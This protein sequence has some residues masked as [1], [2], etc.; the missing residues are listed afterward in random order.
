MATVRQYSSAALQ[1]SHQAILQARSS[2]EAERALLEAF[3]DRGVAGTCAFRYPFELISAKDLDILWGEDLSGELDTV[4]VPEIAR[5]GFQKMPNWLLRWILA[6]PRPYHLR[7]YSRYVPFSTRLILKSTTAPNVRPLEDLLLV[8]YQHRSW[9]FGALLGFHRPPGEPEL[10]S[11]VLLATAYLA[12]QTWNTD[13]KA[14]PAL[15]TDRQLECLQWIVAGKSM[16]ETARITRM[17]YS[18]V[19]Y[20]LERAKQQAG[21]SSLQQLVAFAAVEYGL[22]PMGPTERDGAGSSNRARA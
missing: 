22:S 15:L 6:R 9:G 19:R 21:F 10:E 1:E 4:T 8:T 16:E 12:R 11:L 5:E 13:R 17:S 20:H 2:R 18:N 7:R 3:R 14:Q